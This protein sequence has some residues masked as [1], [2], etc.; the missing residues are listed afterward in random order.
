MKSQQILGVFEFYILYSKKFKLKKKE[1]K[2]GEKTN[3]RKIKRKNRAKEEK[4]SKR[5][6]KFSVGIDE[7][8]EGPS[9]RIPK[10]QR[11]ERVLD[12]EGSGQEESEK[13]EEDEESE[14]EETSE[15]EEEA[16]EES[17]GEEELEE[18]GAEQGAMSPQTSRDGSISITLT[19]PEV[20]D[21]SICYEALTIPV[22]QVGV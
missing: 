11:S 15:G 14:G 22:F 8:G 13:E 18:S 7:D 1:K 16:S 10:R 5:M 4:K 9:N 20:L 6:A 3:K 12:I 2:K 21:C 17:E 19:D